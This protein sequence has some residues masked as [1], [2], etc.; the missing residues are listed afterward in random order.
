M[1]LP[2]AAASRPGTRPWSWLKWALPVATLIIGVAIG[3]G[4]SGKQSAIDQA[5]AKQKAADK[6]TIDRQK[7][8]NDNLTQQ[9]Q[10]TA[11]EFA[12]AEASAKSNAESALKTRIAAVKAREDA[13]AR[14]EKA[15]G[16][17]E[18]TQAANTIPG[19][20]TFVVGSDIK[21]GTYRA[22]AQAG[23]YWARLKDLTN[24]LGSILAND[25]ADGPIVVSIL[26]SD[27]AFNT[28][29]CADFHKIG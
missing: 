15:A 6:V 18:A 14:R 12:G 16:I 13:V 1:A 11:G 2:A 17:A 8:A 3:S 22:A 29:G 5:V 7:S 21:P 28:N 10:Q 4:A 19:T 27:K 24:G 26:P 9:L 25:N 20:G 23:C